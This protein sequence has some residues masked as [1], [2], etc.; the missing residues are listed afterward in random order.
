MKKKTIIMITAIAV[1]LLIVFSLYELYIPIDGKNNQKFVIEIPVECRA[2][3]IAA[4]LEN[5]NIIRNRIYFTAL[6][7]LTSSSKKLKAG[8]YEFSPSMNLLGIYRAIRNGK[9]KLYMLAIPE[10]TSSEGIAKMLSD[11]NLAKKHVFL[12]LVKDGTLCEYYNVPAVTLEGYLFPDTYDIAKGVS[13]REIIK[14]MIK[15]F[16]DVFDIEMRSKAEKM[17]MTWHEAVVLAS[18][19]EKEAALDSERPIIS[20][21]FHNR[22]KKGLNLES[23]ATVLYAIGKPGK[24]LYEKDLRTKSVY[25]TYIYAGLPPS[26]IC[27]PGKNSLIAALNPSD[28]DYLYFVSNGNGTHSFSK[29]Y[30]EHVIAK[31]KAKNR[32]KKNG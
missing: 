12:E 17:G 29:T 7:G 20:A 5:N 13:E 4:I 21:V 14:K 15:R 16:F 11:L 23:C 10:G 32:R 9:S 31:K 3:E 18:I 19:I 2:F 8:E 26:P 22:M 30:K 24:K 25:N 6:V 28:A 1:C 27:N